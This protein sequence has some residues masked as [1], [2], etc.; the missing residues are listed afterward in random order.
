MEKKLINSISQLAIDAGQEILSVYKSSDLEIQT[1]GDGSL[2][3]E[4]DHAAHRTILKGLL[5]LDGNLPVLSEESAPSN[6][7]ERA[8]W[9]RYWL[10]DPLDGTAEFVAGNG[11]FTV[12]I[13]LIENHCP[14][15][16]VVHAPVQGLTYMGAKGLGALVR[17]CHGER[18]IK[19][20][21]VDSVIAR[22]D[23]IV[24]MR[25]RRHAEGGVNPLL[26]NISNKIGPL[27]AKK[28]GSSLKICFIAEGKADL[29]PRL[30]PTSEWD[31]A[32]AHAILEA[33]GG[34]VIDPDFKKLSY[35]SKADL[36]NPFFF[37]IGDPNYD[38]PSL[39]KD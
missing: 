2:V 4:A 30:G 19:T 20:R 10:V 27:K 3:T 8:S 28:M 35:N 34:T 23:S 38:W 33:A 13:A 29:Y 17:D 32:A 6:I 22:K 26:K 18:V 15:L 39:I 24:I 9:G 1:K 14:R 37:A 7:E 12:N 36:L 11:E 31:T 5:K 16:G 21:T 25:S